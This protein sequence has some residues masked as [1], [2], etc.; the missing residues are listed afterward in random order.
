MCYCEF[1]DIIGSIA[2]LDADVIS[3]ETSRSNMEL[4]EAFAD[5]RYPNEIG[6]GVWDIHSPRVPEIAEMVNLLHKAAAVLPIENLWVNPDC[7]L[8][9]RA[10][11]EVIPSLRNMV[12]AAAVLREAHAQVSGVDVPVP[13]RIAEP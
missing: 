3:I 6:P 1:N 7:G 2:A 8:K 5:F 11:K 4:L 13:T 9:T 10:W 12:K